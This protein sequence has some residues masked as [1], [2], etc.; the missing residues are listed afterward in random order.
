MR[1][2]NCFLVL[3]DQ[4]GRLVLVAAVRRTMDLLVDNKLEAAE[5]D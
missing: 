1:S 3:V 2:L 5:L 4:V